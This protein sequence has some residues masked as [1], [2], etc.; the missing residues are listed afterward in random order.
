MFYKSIINITTNN[1]T[2]TTYDLQ[3]YT[4]RE[5]FE[6]GDTSGVTHMSVTTDE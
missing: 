5:I 6:R 2:T 1:K 4:S 3:S